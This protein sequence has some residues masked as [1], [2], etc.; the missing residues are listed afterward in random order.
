MPEKLDGHVGVAD[1]ILAELDGHLKHGEGKQSHPAS[2][3]SLMRGRENSQPD[4]R[5][6]K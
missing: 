5:E 4:G 6:G 3:V 1:I 2:T